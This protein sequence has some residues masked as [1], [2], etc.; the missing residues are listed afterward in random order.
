M[1]QYFLVSVF[2]QNLTATGY[3]A[4]KGCLKVRLALSK[5]RRNFSLYWT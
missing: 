1:K 3:E 5:C 4:I 2:F